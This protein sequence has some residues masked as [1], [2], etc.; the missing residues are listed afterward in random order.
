MKNKIQYAYTITVL[1]G[2]LMTAYLMM[3]KEGNARI[4]V[5]AFENPSLRSDALAV[6]PGVNSL[7]EMEDQLSKLP[8]EKPESPSP[9]LSRRFSGRDLSLK[10]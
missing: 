10:R 2:V 9:S 7:F 1:F 8:A 3:N 6:D 4:P 5:R